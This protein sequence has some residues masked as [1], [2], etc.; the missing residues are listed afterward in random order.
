MKIIHKKFF[1]ENS[2]KI[3]TKSLVITHQVGSVSQDDDNVIRKCH[4][5]KVS[6]YLEIR[7]I[8]DLVWQ[9]CNLWDCYK[10]VWQYIARYNFCQWNK[11]N[12][13]KQYN[14]ITQLNALN[15]LWT[16]ITMNFIVK[17]LSLKNS[18]W[19]IM[20]NNILIIV[21]WLTKYIM[22]IFFKE[23]ATASILT[24]IILQELIS[25]HKLLKEFI[26]DK[27]KL[28]TSK[29]WRTFTAKFEI[30]H[31]LLTAYH[32]QMNEQSEWMN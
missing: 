8:K 3:L 4:E 20:F 31:K 17:L 1:R 22:F 25:N 13:S 28:F 5:T 21:D 18:V 14:R 27:N 29:F 2:E 32:S 26:I 12:C 23:T 6:K 30:K 7:R 10:R 19:D 16:S 11:I 9:K 15:V 24:H